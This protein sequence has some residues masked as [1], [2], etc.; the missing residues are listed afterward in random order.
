M[1]RNA[2][3]TAKSA[4]RYSSVPKTVL[5]TTANIADTTD[6]PD[7]SAPTITP[8]MAP[9]AVSPRHQMPRTSSGQ[10][11]A[12]ATANTSGTVMAKSSRVT[13]SASAIGATMPSTAASR[14]RCRRP[15]STS[16]NSTPARLTSSPDDVA[17]NAAA[18]P[19]AT[20]AASSQPPQFS[21]RAAVGS[22][23]TAAS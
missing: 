10:N 13:D 1:V 20:S 14:N 4:G 3:G 7:T 2:A 23:N 11:V 9:G 19:A 18:A 5:G 15:R 17:R 6:T 21:P 22:S 8:A 12:A 16:V